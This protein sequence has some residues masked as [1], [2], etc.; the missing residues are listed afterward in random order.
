MEDKMDTEQI[1][2]KI[3]IVVKE[4]I[5]A[6]ANNQYEKL[7]TITKLD[8][9]WYDET[10]DTVI[11]IQTFKN[12]IETNYNGWAEDEG[13]PFVINTFTSKNLLDDLQE[14][15]KELLE[16]GSSFLSYEL[17][18]IDDDPDCFF[19]EFDLKLDSKN[20]ITTIINLNF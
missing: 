20:Q 6:I 3:E 2:Q 14:I 16:N 19:L 7:E 5:N 8:D 15:A 9:S 11:A 13:K 1:K 4:I 10:K 17:K 12:V 18:T